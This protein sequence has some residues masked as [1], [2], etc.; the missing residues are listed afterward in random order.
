[1]ILKKIPF[2]IYIIIITFFL[3]SSYTFNSK[4]DLNGDNA[5]YY[6]YAKSLASGH[7]YSDLSSPG[8]PAT[9]NFPPGYSILMAPLFWLTDSIVVQNYLGELFLLASVILLNLFTVSY[10][11]NKGF[12]LFISIIVLSNFFILQFATMMMSEL[13]YIFFSIGVLW[14]LIK[15]NEQSHANRYDFIIL[16]LIAVFAYHIRTQGVVL[17]LSIL[18]QFLFNKKWKNALFSILGFALGVIPWI[19]RNKYLNLEGSRYLSQTMLIDQL[20]PDKG[21]LPI[22]KVIARTVDQSW[23]IITKEMPRT[24]FSNFI[25]DY[26]HNI[27]Y[28]TLGA[29]ILI[30]MLYGSWKFIKLRWFLVSFIIGNIVI[31]GI[32][33]GKGFENRYLICILPILLFCFYFGIMSLLKQIFKLEIKSTLIWIAASLI[34]LLV[35]FKDIKFLHDWNI[36]KYPETYANFFNVAEWAKDNTPEKSIVSV[37]KPGLFYIY[38]NRKAIN[39][40]YSDNPDEVIKD[41]VKS[42]VDYVILDALEYSTTYKFLI[43]AIKKHSTQFQEIYTVGKPAFFLLKFDKQL[44]Q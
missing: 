9:A 11:K 41:M 22:A 21:K 16:I 25:E 38:S 42:K 30:I 1:M 10:I 18:T 39:Y 3:L 40:L 24:I 44:P 4:L 43:P 7:G 20:N 6:I 17:L 31:M 12:A 29:I 5:N 8:N 14:Y 26:A 32:W 34:M 36:E 15:I 27:F 28:P 33:S 2:E 13:P 35:Q 37:R 19:L 23:D